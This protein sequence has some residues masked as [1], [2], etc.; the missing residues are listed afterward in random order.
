MQ[1]E[2]KTREHRQAAA[3][4][5]ALTM[6][7]ALLSLPGCGRG[8][9]NAPAESGPSVS[10]FKELPA[11]PDPETAD[12]DQPASA[13][14]PEDRKDGAPQVPQEQGTVERFQFGDLAV[15]VSRVK[16]VKQGSSVLGEGETWDYDIYAVYPG[17][18]AKVITAGTFIDEETGLPH[19][20]WAFYAADDSRTDILDGMEPLEITGDVLGIVSKESGAYVLGFEICGGEA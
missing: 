2:T 14:S 19:A 6:A 7:L 8:A 15:E 12:Q 4:A 5:A 20:D 1:H 3:L 18:A 11:P 13:G 16:E 17:A 10:D 9:P